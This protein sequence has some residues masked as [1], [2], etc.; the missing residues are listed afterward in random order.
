MNCSWNWKGAAKRRPFQGRGSKRIRAMQ[1]YGTASGAMRGAVR[2]RQPAS[3]AVAVIATVGVAALGLVVAACLVAVHTAAPA[4]LVDFPEHTEDGAPLA[5]PVMDH[6]MLGT[7]PEDR[8]GRRAN[9]ALHVIGKMDGTGL[10]ALIANGT[11]ASEAEVVDPAMVEEIHAAMDEQSKEFDI[12][13]PASEPFPFEAAMGDSSEEG[14]GE[15]EGGEG[16]GEEDGEATGEESGEEEP[17]A[18]EGE[19]EDSAGEDGEEESADEGANEDSA[20]DESG[21]AE[22]GGDEAAAADQEPADSR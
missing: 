9:W 14:A 8:L 6:V 11:I 3:P 22:E 18:D 4:A 1:G 13:A 2:T 10:D 16:E 19:D 21:D 15:D 5:P 7:G 17:P 20:E 12:N